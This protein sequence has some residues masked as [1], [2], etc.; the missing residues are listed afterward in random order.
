M[1]RELLLGAVAGTEPPAPVTLDADALTTHGVIL[2]MTGSGKTGLAVVMLEELARRRVPLILCDLKGD[3]TNLLLTFPTL[4][5]AAFA[6]YLPASQ[7][8]ED[9][10]AAAREVA[11]TWRRG[12]ARWSLGGEQI[13]EVREGLDWRLLTPGSGVAPVDLL[14]ALAAPPRWD[15][16]TDPDG[17]RAR[18]DGTASAIL[19]LVGRGGDPLSDRDHVLVA[20]LLDAAWR[21]GADLDFPGLIRQVADPPVAR[22]G[23]LDTESFYPARERHELVLALNTLLASPSFGAWTKGVPLSMASFI[24]EPDRPRGTILYLA[25][26]GERERLSF[27][28]LVFSEVLAWT[29]L[30]PGSD[31]LRVLLYLDEVQGI[32]P[33]SA[34]PATK[35][36]L[37]TLFKQ[38][39]AFGTGVVVATQN[40][41]DLD[42][43][44]LGNAGIKLIGRLDTANDR[45]RALEGLDLRDGDVEETVAGLDRRQFLLA[46]ARAGAPR[47]LASRWAMS[48]LRGPLTLAEVR[49]LAAPASPAVTPPPP[50]TAPPLLPGVD[51]LFG[52]GAALVP[53]VLVE[54][55]VVYR[56]SAPPLFR[57]VEGRWL[58]PLDGAAGRVS[59]ERLRAVPAA[60]LAASPAV[61]ATLAVLPANAAALLEG[62]A[63]AFADVVDSR[64]L[65]LAWHRGLR[66][67][68]EEGEAAEAFVRRCR[69][70]AEEA[71]EPKR[72]RIRRRYEERL[73]RLD[74]RLA[75]ERLEL[76]GDRQDL[77]SRE[78]EKQ[79]SLVTGV[80]DALLSGLGALLGGG[81]GVRGAVRR[82]TGTVR[83]YE[84]KERLA[85]HARAEVAESEQTIA[86]LTAERARLEEALAAELAALAG[87]AGG[88][89]PGV[90]PLLVTPA[91]KDIGVRRVALAWLPPEALA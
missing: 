57:R 24:G 29:R 46:G 51:Q 70:A 63:R 56:K 20:T 33:P 16:D 47:V 1:K 88:A 21:H 43:K 23:V 67:V 91:R 61:G 7:A 66:L 71:L 76:E 41:V 9:R 65:E 18:L 27:L 8:G 40:P 19:A 32:V 49:P 50:V 22:F 48:Y 84:T 28:T 25:H 38:G 80:G 53:A 74:D 2:G 30:Q 35:R 11:E 39:R 58:A 60:A 3:L 5:G 73:R 90:E 13:R 34:Q 79:V 10:V 45:R 4:D 89:G 42:Y 12:L 77:T 14:P 86:A 54:A 44:A 15:P 52:D 62:A 36:P 83:S 72:E 55:E 82:G 87:E 75:R 17:A 81:R 31:T 64:P 78:R 26:L 68:Q 69:E 59:W 6:P 37:L 85:E